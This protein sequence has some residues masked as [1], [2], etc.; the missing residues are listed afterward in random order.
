MENTEHGRIS[1]AH[2]ASQQED[3]TVMCKLM[4]ERGNDVNLHN[5]DTTQNLI[6][7]CSTCS[8]RYWLQPGNTLLIMAQ[9]HQ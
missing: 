5:V 4:L 6:H 2:R 8:V 9:K 7:F 3:S 1:S